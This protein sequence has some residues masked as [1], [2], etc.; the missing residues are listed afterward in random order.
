V[1]G[2]T[3]DCNNVSGQR[4]NEWVL[5]TWVDS[6]IFRWLRESFLPSLINQH[7]EY[8]EPDEDDPLREALLPEQERHENGL[9]SAPPPENAVLFCHLPGQVRH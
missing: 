5:D 3:E 7:A 4:F 8:S 2:D 1:L 6:L 9:P